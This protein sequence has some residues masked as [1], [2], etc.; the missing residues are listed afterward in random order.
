MSQWIDDYYI[1]FFLSI[2]ICNI[3]TRSEWNGRLL[4]AT[5]S[6]KNNAMLYQEIMYFAVHYHKYREIQNWQ[7]AVLSSSAAWSGV[8][9]MFSWSTKGS[10]SNHLSASSIWWAGQSFK[11]QFLSIY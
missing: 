6:V 3:L 7:E 5:S 8:L 11:D 1:L 10:H 9:N 2:S 4:T